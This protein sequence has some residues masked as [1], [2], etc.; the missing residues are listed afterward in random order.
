MGQRGQKYSQEF[1]D[2][3][4]QHVL[5]SDKSIYQIA[6]DLDVSDKTL[7]SWMSAYK[8]KHNLETNRS[9]KSSK[10][11]LEEENRRLRKELATVKKEREILK[12]AT[13]YFAK[14]TH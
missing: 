14:E 10:E 13:A 1:K 12:K 3:T 2:S 6:K 7:Y 9:K 4:I 5:S 11:T 8:K